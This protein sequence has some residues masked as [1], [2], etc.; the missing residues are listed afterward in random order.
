MMTP[1]EIKKIAE[2]VHENQI[3][4]ASAANLAAVSTGTET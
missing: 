3:A 4:F 2:K 1:D